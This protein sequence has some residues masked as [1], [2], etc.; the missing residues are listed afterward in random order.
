MTTDHQLLVQTL[1]ITGEMFSGGPNRVSEVADEW[2]GYGF[3][4]EG[5]SDWIAA[6]VWNPDVA[7]RLHAD[8][9]RPSQLADFYASDFYRPSE[10]VYRACAGLTSSAELISCMKSAR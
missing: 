4:T 1:T 5:A 9:I 10:I 3:D 6:D 2:L 7:D 8:G